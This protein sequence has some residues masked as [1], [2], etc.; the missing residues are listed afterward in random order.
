MNNYLKEKCKTDDIIILYFYSIPCPDCIQQG[1]VLDDLR[2]SVFKDKLKVFVLD[3]NVE[4]P[5]IDIL[6]KTYNITQTPSFVLQD[7]SYT[8]FVD[9]NSFINIIQKTKM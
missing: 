4:E 2:E 7:K 9:K 3:I 8:G 1:L 5:M 6:K